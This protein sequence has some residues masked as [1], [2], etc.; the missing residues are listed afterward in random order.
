MESKLNRFID[1]E[2]PDSKLVIL[3]R[4]KHSILIEAP[5]RVAPHLR[6]QRHPSHPAPRPDRVIRFYLGSDE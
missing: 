6:D 4:L 1:A 2:L 3:D 5:E